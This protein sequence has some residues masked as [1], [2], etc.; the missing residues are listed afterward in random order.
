MSQ[1]FNAGR[2]KYLWSQWTA[3]AATKEETEEL[4]SIIRNH[5]TEELQKFL[6]IDY[7]NLMEEK[8]DE[9]SKSLILQNILKKSHDTSLANRRPVRINFVRYAAAV[10]LLFGLAAATYFYL[11]P[12]P[13]PQVATTNERE[14]PLKDIQPGTQRA[15]LTLSDGTTIELDNAANG[16][17]AEQQ[18][19]KISK[20][21]AQITYLQ[22]S[23]PLSPLTSH[24]SYNTMTTPRGGLYHLILPDGTKVWLNAASS[25]T[26]PTSFTGNTREVSITG[27]LYF[28]VTK[29]AAKPF[30][31]KTYRDEIT[32][33]GT[34]FNI[35]SYTDEQQIKTS[36]LEGSVW[37]GNTELKPGE[38]FSN[39]KVFKADVNMDVAWKNGSFAFRNADLQ[40]VM[41]QLARWYNLDV[42][43][44]GKIPA[45]TFSGEIGRSLT[46][47]Q[48]LKGLTTTKIKYRLEDRNKLVIVSK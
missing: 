10:V 18:G 1:T 23:S 16:L 39:G 7:A 31:V 13:S 9:E 12:T 3:R 27:E 15:I 19:S 2:L 25:I 5:S 44:E 8:M 35:N 20:S 37:I 11:K 48:L 21:G 24:T 17:L 6:P 47:N 43:Y 32:V 45:G 34:S 40:T 38:A 36:L 28:E 29:N 42:V 26:Y 41:R 4:F 46:L 33:R 14:E 30:I 22:P